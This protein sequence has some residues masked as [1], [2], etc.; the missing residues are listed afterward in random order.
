[1]APESGPERGSGM[2]ANVTFASAGEAAVAGTPGQEPW[3]RQKAVKVEM[4]MSASIKLTGIADPSGGE[5]GGGLEAAGNRS[6]M[7]PGK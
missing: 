4:G 7:V 3:I 6:Q 5:H 2:P 1:M